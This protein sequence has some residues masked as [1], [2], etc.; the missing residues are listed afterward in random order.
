M[1]IFKNAWFR[2]FA[3][4]EEIDDQRLLEAIA[5][6]DKGLIDADLGGCVIKQRIAKP[7]RGRSG[8]Y[9]TIIIFKQDTRAFFVYGF[10]KSKR[11]NIEKHE[12]EAFRR[13]AKELLALSDAQ[14]AQLIEKKE[15]T[16][17]IND[18]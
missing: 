3:R 13:A 5:R 7:G 18:D 15:L 6:A 1:R 2:R 16:E 12:E 9:R 17:V 11:D 10:A 14:I 8:G 4:Q